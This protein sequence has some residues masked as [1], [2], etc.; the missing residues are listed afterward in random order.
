MILIIMKI[1]VQNNKDT[2]KLI[3]KEKVNLNLNY[4]LS[5]KYIY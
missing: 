2:I 3:Y 1:K 5:L 4:H